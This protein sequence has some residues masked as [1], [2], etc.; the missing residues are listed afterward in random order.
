MEKCNRVGSPYKS[1]YVIGNIPDDGITPKAKPK[2]V[3]RYQSL[4]G[5]LE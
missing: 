5:V 3:K 2:L 4:V 1:G